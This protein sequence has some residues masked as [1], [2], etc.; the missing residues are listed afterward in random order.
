[1]VF[2]DSN[3][4][5]IDRLFRRDAAYPITHAFLDRL[6][7]IS[8]AVPLITLLELCGAASFRLSA[9]ETELWLQGFA[10]VYPVKILNPFGAGD[11]PATAWLGS[12][13][14]DVSRYIARRMTFGDALLAREADRYGADA[15]VTWN[16]KDFA[17]KTAVRVLTPEQFMSRGLEG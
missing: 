13:T 6:P 8:A 1:L 9:D 15:I 17:G 14:D 3:L 16:I 11:G 5:I 4:F 2:L 7:K 12:Y 10:T